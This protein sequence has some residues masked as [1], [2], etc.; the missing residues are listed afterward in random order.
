MSTSSD[1]STQREIARAEL[2]AALETLATKAFDFTGE[3]YS[4]AMAIGRVAHADRDS[5]YADLMRAHAAHIYATL[6]TLAAE[7]AR[8]DETAA[9]FAALRD[10]PHA[11]LA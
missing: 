8:A 9:L 1:Y 2:A 10:V 5:V 6:E 11:A 3:R 7:Q 4:A